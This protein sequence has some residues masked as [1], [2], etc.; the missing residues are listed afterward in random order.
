MGEGRQVLTEDMWNGYGTFP[1]VCRAPWG[2]MAADNRLFPEAGPVRHRTDARWR[3]LPERFGKC[4]SV[5]RRFRHWVDK[6]VS[7]RVFQRLSREFD[8]E[9]VCVDGAAMSAH[10]KASGGNGGTRA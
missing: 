6:V 10:Q 2:V 4:S 9:Y 7:A 5:F 8:L 1:R 3:D